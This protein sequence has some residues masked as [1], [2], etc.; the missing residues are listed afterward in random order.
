MT[1]ELKIKSKKKSILGITIAIIVAIVVICFALF[2][3]SGSTQ[4]KIDKKLDIAQKYLIELDYEQAIIEFSEILEIDTTCVDAYLGIADAYIGQSDY[5]SA[6]AILE[7]G[8]EKADS[9]LLNN[10]LNE[11]NAEIERIAEKERKAQ[12]EADLKAKKEAEKAAKEEATGEIVSTFNKHIKAFVEAPLIQGKSWVT[13]APLKNTFIAMGNHD[14]NNTADEYRYRFWYDSRWVYEHI[15][16]GSLMDFSFLDDGRYHFEVDY[17]YNDPGNL[18]GIGKF[19]TE[20]GLVTYNDYVEYLTGFESHE[21]FINSGLATYSTDGVY[22]KY[23]IQLDTDY[24]PVTIVVAPEMN[25]GMMDIYIW[26]Y[27]DD[28][29]GIFF[30]ENYPNF[31]DDRIRIDFYSGNDAVFNK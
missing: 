6:K 16:A 4:R 7:Q 24:G 29:W 12:E 31:D 10:K 26:D 17:L 21:A 23:E 25:G 28:I 18:G 27:L 14:I 2:Y 8:I 20:N 1:E 3:A 30:C 13:Y 22:D 19:A 15:N 11:V 9:E 5:E